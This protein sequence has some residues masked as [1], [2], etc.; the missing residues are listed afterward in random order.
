M[1]FLCGLTY[2]FIQNNIAYTSPMG[3]TPLSHLAQAAAIS[4]VIY[5]AI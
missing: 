2:K 1:L 5:L 3:I 4:S